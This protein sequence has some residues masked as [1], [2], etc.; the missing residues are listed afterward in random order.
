MRTTIFTLLFAVL[1][2]MVLVRGVQVIA[3]STPEES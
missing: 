2:V 1:S 3:R